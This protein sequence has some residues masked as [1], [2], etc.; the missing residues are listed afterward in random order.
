MAPEY[1]KKLMI[2][3]SSFLVIFLIFFFFFWRPKFAEL[4][5]LQKNLSEKQ[6]ELIQLERDAEDWPDSITRERL[7][8][9][10]EELSQLWELIPSKE[11]VAD[12]LKD[13]QSHAR[14]S[15]LEIISLNRVTTPG[16]AQT[17]A[18]KESRYVKV[19]YKLS[20][21]GDYF[22]LIT[23]LRKLEDSKRLV[24]IISTKVYT[25]E[26]THSLGA[27]VQ[28]NVYYSRVGVEAS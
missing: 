1:I 9:Y 12:L 19:P 5:T 14:N 2:V 18:E 20:V 24:T 25:G 6:A 16:R 21:G 4:R 8:R 27:E 22:G 17:T 15:S 13:I 7:R 3:V 28:F 26:G 10:E 11:E 23:F